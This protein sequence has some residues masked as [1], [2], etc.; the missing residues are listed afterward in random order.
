MVTDVAQPEARR[1]TGGKLDPAEAQ[2]LAD[3]D[4]MALRFTGWLRCH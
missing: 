2:K 3:D 4:K 1:L